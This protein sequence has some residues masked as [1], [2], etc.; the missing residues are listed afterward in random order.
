MVSSRYNITTNT[1]LSGQTAIIARQGARFNVSSGDTLTINVPF[2]AGAYRVFEGNGEVRFDAGS[3]K[4]V[5][6]QWWADIDSSTS[7]V[8]V[9]LAIKKASD[10]GIKNLYLPGGIYKLNSV[11]IDKNINIHGAGNYQQFY[12]IADNLGY[13]LNEFLNAVGDGATIINM[14]STAI[15]SPAF[16][17]RA[18]ADDGLIQSGLHISDLLFYQKQDYNNITAYPYAISDTLST[19]FWDGVRIERIGLLN[20]YKGIQLGAAERVEMRDIYGDPLYRGITGSVWNDVSKI[21]RIHFW[22]FAWSADAD[23]FRTSA[24][25]SYGIFLDDVDEVWL[26][27]IF[28]ISREY[29]IYF[30]KFWGSLTH[31]TFDV[32]GNPLIINNPRSVGVNLTDGKFIGNSRVATSDALIK[33][34]GDENTSS[35]TVN[36]DKCHFFQGSIFPFGFNDCI[37]IDYDS[38]NV[39]ITNSFFKAGPK[40][41][42]HVSDVSTISMNNVLFSGFRPNQASGSDSIET[43]AI[44]NHP[45][46][47]RSGSFSNIQFGD[48]GVN[49][50]LMSYSYLYDVVFD[51]VKFDYGESIIET[52]PV[53]SVHGSGGTLT[54]NYEDS[55]KYVTYTDN[56]NAAPFQGI[57]FTGGLNGTFEKD[58]YYTYGVVYKVTS[59]LKVDNAADKQNF[60]MVGL[61]DMNNNTELI[62]VVDPEVDTNRKLTIMSVRADTSG[63]PTYGPF[64]KTFDGTINIYNQFIT[65][66]R[67]LTFPDKSKQKWYLS[68]VPSGSGRIDLVG[69]TYSKLTPTIGG[70]MG[71]ICTTKGSPGTWAEFGIIDLSGSAIWDAPS[72]PA[73]SIQSNDITVTGAALGDYAVVSSSIDIQELTLS[74]NVRTTDTVEITLHNN[75]GGAINLGSAT[76]NV[77]VIKP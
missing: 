66:G 50:N 29:G 3:T 32:V 77:K 17:I 54:A 69:E 21:E 37:K 43:V 23:S 22:N 7:G 39:N 55:L 11:I 52:D 33:I 27:D 34:T 63:I 61:P 53:Y 18:G 10:S 46:N 59:K 42:L 68:S 36:I 47:L 40:H 19:R 74:A 28:I 31:F 4:E 12:R 5:L 44:Y 35:A 57:R 15:D 24:S 30:N 14:Q 49:T 56:N 71:W 62:A 38:V 9:A 65:K 8:I 1:T 72:V 51:N 70:T 75:S 26:S 45:P 13:S 76:Y 41:G 20:V 25:S 67:T 16:N 48:N 2:Y 6:P 64:A 58:Q 73:D 60:R